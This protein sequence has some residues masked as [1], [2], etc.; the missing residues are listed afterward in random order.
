MKLF[1]IIYDTRI[2]PS[3]SST[4]LLEQHLTYVISYVATRHNVNKIFT[5][6]NVTNVS[7]SIKRTCDQM[8]NTF[9]RRQILTTI[10][11]AII[12]FSYSTLR[13]C[14]LTTPR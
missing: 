2:L 13:Q 12:A 6:V 10:L 14:F 1:A 5:Y 3:H 9:T 11:N 7:L 8:R 4:K